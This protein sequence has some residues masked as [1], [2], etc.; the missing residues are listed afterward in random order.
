MKPSKTFPADV[1]THILKISLK[2]NQLFRIAALALPL[3]LFVVIYQK[4]KWQPRTLHLPT[5]PFAEVTRVTFSPDGRW[6]V[7]AAEGTTTEAIF[8]WDVQSRKL[9]RTIHPSTSLSG[10]YTVRFTPRSHSLV[11]GGVHQNF[12]V[13]NLYNIQTG[14]VVRRLP[15]QTTVFDFTSNERWMA[16]SSIRDEVILEDLS[17]SQKVSYRQGAFPKNALDTFSLNGEALRGT[18]YNIAF[19]PNEKILAVARAT[20]EV[21]LWEVETRHL[22]QTL[23][24]HRKPVTCIAFSPDGKWLASGSNIKPWGARY[25]YRSEKPKKLVDAIISAKPDPRVLLWDLKTGKVIQ[26]FDTDTD[27]IRD[28]AFSPDGTW[29]A[30]TTNDTNI[31]LW[32]INNPE[33]KRVLEGHKKKVNSIAFSPDSQSLLSG[34]ED[35]TAKLWRIQ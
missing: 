18:I 31:R 6:A 11:L 3:L 1:S 10:L 2:R 27:G 9:I 22:L 13:T 23:K 26:S 33:E 8:V 25:Y 24:G 29:L 14:K 21:Q 4:R 30:C 32:N 7:I 15:W 19:S 35:G 20:A 28:V 5:E 34:S 12:Q 16:F 17:K